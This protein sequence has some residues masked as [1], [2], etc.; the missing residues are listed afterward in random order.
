MRRRASGI[1]RLKLCC[2]SS[3]CSSQGLTNLNKAIFLLK[4]GTSLPCVLDRVK[5]TTIDVW[6]VVHDGGLLLL[7]PFLLSQHKVWRS[8]VKIRLFAVLTDA[9]EN[10]VTVQKR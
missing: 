3:L 10:P 9:K 4:G 6:W 1:N 5:S 2:C 7:V 8:G